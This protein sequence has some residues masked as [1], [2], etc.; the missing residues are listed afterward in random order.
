MADKNINVCIHTET[1]IDKQ[2]QHWF[3]S[4][5]K[6]F[7]IEFICVSLNSG[8]VCC[9]SLVFTPILDKP[10]TILQTVDYV[11]KWFAALCFQA[12]LW[13]LN[14]PYLFFFSCRNPV[15]ILVLCFLMS[16]PHSHQLCV[17]ILV[18]PGDHPSCQHYL[19][20]S[21]ATYYPGVDTCSIQTF[22][23]C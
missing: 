21:V 3:P 5:K 10:E 11:L 22:V 6:Y 1:H 2:P 4:I 13:T 9:I 19:L 16:C 15:L 23:H 12:W 18:S 14:L 17:S 8:P 20:F 7:H